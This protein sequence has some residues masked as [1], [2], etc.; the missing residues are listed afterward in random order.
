[1]QKITKEEFLA[2]LEDG[3]RRFHGYKFSQLDL[4]DLKGLSNIRFSLCDFNLTK[5]D[6]S[7]MPNCK[8]TRCE[9]HYVGFDKTENSGTIFEHCYF[10]GASFFDMK[11][12]SGKFN[13]CESLDFEF[14]G[15]ADLGLVEIKE[16]CQTRGDFLKY[17]IED[18]K[19][20]K[21]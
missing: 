16:R 11:M 3:T 4:N 19:Q 5:F 15:G 1:M 13:Y 6:G 12:L 8:F 2:L 10:N 21:K 9:F 20:C 7:I 18:K 17:I 14:F